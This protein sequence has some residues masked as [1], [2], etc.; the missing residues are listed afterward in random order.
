MGI[1]FLTSTDRD[2]DDS[3][4]AE[5]SRDPIAR[6]TEAAV[7]LGLIRPGDALDR[8]MIDLCQRVVEMAAAIGD[9]HRIH[10]LIEDTVGD[11]I[12]AALRD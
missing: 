8:N 10:G 9:R 11:R 4:I 1:G 5:D 3:V 2:D 12:R 7:D 6:F